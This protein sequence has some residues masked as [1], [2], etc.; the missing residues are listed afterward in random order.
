MAMNRMQYRISRLKA[1]QY[2][3]SKSLQLVSPNHQ[4]FPR[5]NHANKNRSIG[6]CNILYI[7]IKLLC[8]QLSIQNVISIIQVIKKCATCKH[9]IP[10]NHCR[11]GVSQSSV[12]AS[13]TDPMRSTNIK[14]IKKANMFIFA[15][16]GVGPSPIL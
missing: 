14:S 11:I 3:F 2:P 5:I 6:I 1:R 13:I 7:F 4:Q 16:Q 8:S 15:L 10:N 12:E 9:T